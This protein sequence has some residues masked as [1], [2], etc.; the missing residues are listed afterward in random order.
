MHQIVKEV[1]DVVQG[2][3]N[4]HLFI[5]DSVLVLIA[6]WLSFVLRLEQMWPEHFETGLAI[7]SLAALISIP[8]MFMGFRLYSR[9]WRY[10]AMRDWLELVTAIFI[11][12]TLTAGL[13]WTVLIFLPDIAI[14]RSI[15]LIFL[16]VI[17][18]LL[19][20]TTLQSLRTSFLWL[21]SRTQ[22]IRQGPKA[23]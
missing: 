14:P 8:G 7:F 10:A 9:Y 13:T 12:S 20:R 18:I 5:V 17:G 16:S 3:R 1:A 15:P 6:T 19:I 11:G 22:Y 21:E 23:K 4:R 2:V